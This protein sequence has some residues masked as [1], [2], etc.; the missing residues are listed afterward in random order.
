MGVVNKVLHSSEQRKTIDHAWKNVPTG[1]TYIVGSVANGGVAEA[2]QYMAYG[3]SGSP[4]GFLTI[5]RFI[6]GAGLTVIPMGSTFALRDFGVSGVVAF[7]V[8]MPAA[9][10][11]VLVNDLVMYT[12]GAANSAADQIELTIVM[13]PLENVRTY[14]GIV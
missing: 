6:A 2:V 5:H 3:V 14:F 8:S 13:K 12:S 1:A 11:T 9:G 10:V 4:T 7:G